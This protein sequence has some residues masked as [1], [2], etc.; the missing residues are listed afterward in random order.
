MK[1]LGVVGGLGPMTTV[2]FIKRVIDMTDAT[3]DQEHIPMVVEHCCY[4][5]D[6]TAFIL[7]NSEDSPLPSILAACRD[8]EKA[9][10]THIAMPCVTAHY[11]Y[12]ELSRTTGSIF[13]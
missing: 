12:E 8:L 13:A 6:R 1:K 3:I 5:P 2:S 10:A 9:G 4:T 7:G 11:F